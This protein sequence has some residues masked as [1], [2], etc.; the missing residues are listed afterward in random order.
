[1]SFGG[2]QMAPSL[3]S[4]NVIYDSGS[5]VLYI[6]IRN[7]AATRGIEDASGI[8]WRYASDGELIGAT[9]LD[10]QDIWSERQ[11]DLARELSRHFDIP[12]HRAE[13]VLDHA[14]D[15]LVRKNK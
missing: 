6:S 7:E 15:D 13:I 3:K 2:D 12:Q 10:F 4:F 14:M 9:V 5:D 8:V 1:M 11:T